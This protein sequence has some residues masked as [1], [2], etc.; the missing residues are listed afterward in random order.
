M[1]F[2]KS[3]PIKQQ[4]KQEKNFDWQIYQALSPEQRHTELNK[5]LCSII[6]LT[7]GFSIGQ[8]DM[9]QSLLSIGI[10]SLMALQL[11]NAM[12]QTFQLTVPISRLLDGSTIASLTTY[13]FER[14][15]ETQLSPL[16]TTSQPVVSLPSSNV[17]QQGKIA[18]RERL[19]DQGQTPYQKI[20]GEL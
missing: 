12:Q 10:D 8:L 17:H 9:Q 19:S 2:E 5:R 4:T 18:V 7:G 11:R 1:P 13:L 15:E 16:T 20:E 3:N 14:L 6:A